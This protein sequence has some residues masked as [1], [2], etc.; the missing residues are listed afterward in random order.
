[1]LPGEW[2]SSFSGHIAGRARWWKMQ[3]EL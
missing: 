3:D 2:T 1:L